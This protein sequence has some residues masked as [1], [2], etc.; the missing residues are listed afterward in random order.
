MTL[1]I[2]MLQ[3]NHIHL[4]YAYYN[5]NV[6][7]LDKVNNIDGCLP[8]ITKFT[9]I[10]EDEIPDDVYLELCFMSCY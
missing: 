8:S 6:Q 4:Y 1:K 7:P 2:S 9:F 5:Q 10:V 3:F